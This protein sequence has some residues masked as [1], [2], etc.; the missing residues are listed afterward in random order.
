MPFCTLRGWQVT[1]FFWLL[2]TP[3]QICLCGMPETMKIQPSPESL[4]SPW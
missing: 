3:A 1:A 2:Q 4:G